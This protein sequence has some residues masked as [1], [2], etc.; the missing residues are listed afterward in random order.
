M[1]GEQSQISVAVDQRPSERERVTSGPARRWKREVAVVDLSLWLSSK[2]WVFAG[3]SGEEKERGAVASVMGGEQ[4]A[5][6]PW[7]TLDPS[8]DLAPHSLNYFSTLSFQVPQTFFT[9]TLRI[10]GIRR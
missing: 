5:S 9:T 6:G 1:G 8:S 10:K 7:S 4:G 3:E 2:A